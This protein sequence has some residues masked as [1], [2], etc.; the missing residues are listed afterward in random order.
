MTPAVFK[1]SS[2]LE[3]GIQIQKVNNLN[4]FKLTD[5]LQARMQE[6]VNGKT[7]DSLTLEEAA[8]LEAIGELVIIISYING[9]IASEAQKSQETENWEQRIE[10]N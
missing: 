3:N 1:P 6:L 4:L 10:K 8:E 7:S 5:A 2:W 9:M